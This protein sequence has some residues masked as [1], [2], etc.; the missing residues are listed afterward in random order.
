MRTVHLYDSLRQEEYDK[1][2]K[3][4]K[5]CGKEYYFA[6]T[7]SG[8]SDFCCLSCAKKYSSRSNEEEVK[9]KIRKTLRTSTS[10]STNSGLSIKIARERYLKNPKKC[11]NC[12]AVI[13]YERRNRKTCSEE[14]YSVI[15]RTSAMGNP[16]GK[17]GGFR[18]GS[19]RSKSGY[20]DNVFMGSTYELAYYIYQRDHGKEVI[21]NENVFSYIQNG[22]KHTYLPD[23]IVEDTYIEVKGYH[24]PTV[25]I[26][27]QAVHDAG[28]KIEV[29]YIDDLLYMMDYIDEKYG[30]HHRG[31][32]NNYQTLYQDYK[33]KYEYKCDYCGKTFY[34]DEK[35]KTITG[36]VY[37]C[38][39]CAGKG[40]QQFRPTMPEETKKKISESLKKRNAT[41]KNK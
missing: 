20:Y 38:R 34:A 19:G 18:E 13:P 29:F 12:G 39:E 22:K 30:T 3:F 8:R 11:A 28:G 37:C 35:R 41:R 9:E 23:F 4:C 6:Y 16:T 24:T 7:K 36:K 5:H 14:C 25:D 32:S 26:K 10:K 33:P 1:T 31:K 21:R 40:K 17:K 2:L 27:I 15:R